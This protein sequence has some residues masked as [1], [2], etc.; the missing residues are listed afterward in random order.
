MGNP[1]EQRNPKCQLAESLFHFTS[2]FVTLKWSNRCPE[3]AS[4]H[5]DVFRENPLRDVTILSH[6]GSLDLTG[7]PLRNV[8]KLSHPYH[9]SELEN[10]LHNV[11]KLSISKICERQGCYQ[12]LPEHCKGRPARYCSP[13]CRMAAHRQRKRG[14]IR[15]EVH[16]GSATTRSRPEERSWMVKLLRD[17]EELIVTFGQTRDAAERLT[18]RLNDFLN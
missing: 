13:A 15:A 16:F 4:Y 3:C 9:Q 1:C 10:P 14:P 5:S 18:A 11:T 6:S 12:I 17:N 8:T 7:E 2:S